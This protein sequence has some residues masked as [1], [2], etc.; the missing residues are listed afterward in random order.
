MIKTMNFCLWN[1]QPRRD[2]NDRE[3]EEIAGLMDLLESYTLGRREESDEMVWILDK[4]KGFS[5]N[6]MYKGLID[7]THSS[8]PSKC[9]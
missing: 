9:V 3:I 2:L 4:E 7:G 6:T 1:I 8:F 5:V